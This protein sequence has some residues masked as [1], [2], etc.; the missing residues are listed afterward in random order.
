MSL[1]GLNGKEVQFDSPEEQK[2][3][4]NMLSE[5][6]RPKRKVPHAPPSRYL[7]W[8]HGTLAKVVHAVG[9]VEAYDDMYWDDYIAD[10]GLG[11]LNINADNMEYLQSWL[12]EVSESCTRGLEEDKDQGR[13]RQDECSRTLCMS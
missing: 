12:D 11:L 3:Q 13:E 5:E 6:N 4:A 7:L 2:A 9:N 8:L 1:N 10:N